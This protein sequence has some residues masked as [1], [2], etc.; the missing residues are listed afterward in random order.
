MIWRQPRCRRH[1]KQ[2]PPLGGQNFE[3]DFINKNVDSFIFS[4]YFH[5]F[6][7]SFVCNDGENVKI[8]FKNVQFRVIVIRMKLKK[9]K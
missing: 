8:S 4:M 5:H 6:Q 1:R 3:Y 9:H 2:G 7:W